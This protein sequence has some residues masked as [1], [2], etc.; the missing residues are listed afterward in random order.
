M[1]IAQVSPLFESVPPKS[2]GGTERIVSYL[3]DELVRQGHDVT[4]FASGDSSTTARLIP[5]C[6]KALRLDKSCS[7]PIA[8]HIRL[9]D[10][11][12]EHASEFD[13]IHF[14]I[15]YLHFPL[16]A[17][18]NV[19]HV[20]TQHGRL[21]LPDL[22][23]LFRRFRDAPLVSISQ[24]QREPMRWA[25][26]QATVYHGLPETLYHYHET[27]EGYLAF[28]GRISP[29][30]GIDR[31]IEIAKRSGRKIRIAAKVDAA[32]EKYYRELIAPLMEDPVCEFLGEIGDSEKDDFLG[33]AS[34]LLFPIDWP[35]PF[36]VV[37][38]E[39]MAC[40][41]P[42]IA[43]PGGSVEEVVED[44]VSGLVVHDIDEAVGA[45]ENIG[46]LSRWQCYQAFLQRFSARRMANDY[47]RVYKS[48]RLA[49]AEQVGQNGFRLGKI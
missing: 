6:G 8:H 39:A 37:L 18:H 2:Y 46:R 33:N 11:V 13:V 10:V 1:R 19:L 38:I 44:G 25:N 45:V 34:A 35:E 28:L 36:G 27:P 22:A 20:T 31:A 16:T 32:D 47:L 30:K 23:P 43:Y 15:D 48:L 12:F 24:A 49:E 26:W 21:D 41:T 7:D 3:T 9:V 14:H 17:R 40:G 4:L 42:V 5:V 29:E